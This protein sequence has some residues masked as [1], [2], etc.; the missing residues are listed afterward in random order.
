[1]S[2][3]YSVPA[4]PKENVFLGIIGAIIGAIPGV[5][6]W[7]LIGQLG[8]V[9]VICGVAIAIG[10]L[11][12]YAFLGKNI[13]KTGL[14]VCGIVVLVA[15]FVGI[16]FDYYLTFMRVYELTLPEAMYVMQYALAEDA[17]FRGSYIVNLVLGYLCS[18]VGS[19][20]GV[21]KFL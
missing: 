20:A 16:Q 12:G 7:I 6:L 1:M 8:R 15:T 21:S 10:A 11:Y 5:L 14:I 9:A 19:A 4:R 17:S 2:S 18:I 3:N 13:S